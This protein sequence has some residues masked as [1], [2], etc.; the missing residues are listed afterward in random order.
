MNYSKDSLTKS[1]VGWRRG[2]ELG[3][4]MVWWRDGE[5]MQTTVIE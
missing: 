3:S 1:R 4:A 5:N 2:K